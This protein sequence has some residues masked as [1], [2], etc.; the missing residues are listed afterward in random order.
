M[1]GKEGKERNRKGV[2]RRERR[3]RWGEQRGIQCSVE[4]GDR[5]GERGTESSV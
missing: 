5:K 1:C 2:Q 4:G 3:E